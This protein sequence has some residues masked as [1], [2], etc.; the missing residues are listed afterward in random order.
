MSSLGNRRRKGIG[1]VGLC[2]ASWSIGTL[3]SKSI[4]LVKVLH[5]HRDNIA[6]IQETKW[7]GAKA[8]EIDGHKLLYSGCKRSRNRVGIMVGKELV[9]GVVKVGRKSDRIISIKLVVGVE[10]VNVVCVY[11][12]QV[13]LADE[14]KRK[15]WEELKEVIQ[16]MPQTER[17]F[18]GGDFNGYIGTRV[19]GHLLTHGGFGY[20]AR[21]DGGV[22]LL[23]FA[24]AYD[25]T[26]VNSLFKKKVGHL[27]TF[28]TCNTKTQI[29]FFLTRAGTRRLC[30]DCK[31]IPSEHQGTQH[32]LLV[33]DVAIKSAKVK[34]RLVRESKVRWWNLIGENVAKLSEK[35]VA[36][37]N[38][39]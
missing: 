5:R 16:S 28:R 31:V 27:V 33:M 12:P 15:F 32:R 10:I 25:L 36:N 24:V 13:G 34:K 39:R 37:G 29:D 35:I 7:V 20:G 23:D 17:L 14:I 4:E 38:W 11:A 6:C 2:F 22:A 9:D 8:R 19:D 26:I 30:K 1:V 18:L 3:T 21:N